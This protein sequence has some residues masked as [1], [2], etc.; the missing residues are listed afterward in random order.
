[1]LPLLLFA[2]LAHASALATDPLSPA[3]G[4]GEWPA[5][6][7]DRDLRWL[8]PHFSRA[9][10]EFQVPRPLL[11]ALA[12]EA[13][14]WDPEVVSQWGGYGLYD[15]REE[16]GGDGPR[17]EDAAML[18][19]VSPDD[20][21]D[22][23]GLQIRAAAAMLA[24]SAA[25]RGDG[26]LPPVDDL[27][28][29]L[30][31]VASFSGRHA[32]NLQDMYAHYVYDVVEHGAARGGLRLPPTPV[33]RID[34]LDL[35]PPPTS[36]DYSG[37]Y[38]FINAS[39]SNYSNYSRGAADISY[40]VVHTVQGSYSG[41]ISWFQNSSAEVSAHYVVRSSDGQVT[42]MVKEEDVAW[43]AG[44]WDYNLASV[45]IEHEGYVES[46]D[47]WYTDAMYSGSAALVSDIIARNGI[48]ASRDYIIGH[49]EVPGATHTD[50]G[51]GWDW[52]TYMSL[53]SG[54]EVT[55]DVI[56]VVADSDIYS[57]DRLVGATVRI[58][59]TGETTTVE[60]DGYYRFYDLPLGSYTMVASYPG[61]DEGSCAKE[62]ASGTNW[63]SIALLPGGG[64]TETGDGGATDGGAT[65]GGTAG[66]GGGG[67]D[68]GP[69]TDG[70][71]GSDGGAPGGDP[72]GPGPVSPPGGVV[73]L[74]DTR[75]G[76]ATAP[77]RAA[78]WLGLA[79]LLGLLLGR[80]RRA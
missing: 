2:G 45:G 48:P 70:G 16:D 62:L 44:N 40:V 24:R 10:A 43:H 32:P 21:V 28:A 31:A 50:P 71:A 6:E 8:G 1:M 58:A 34:W 73:A 17:L 55:G 68:T 59:E 5:S 75:A 37:C 3:S 15:L 66:D 46:P 77:A 67:T 14:R 63:C 20:L 42:Q 29:W 12:W 52:D 39:S 64:G 76:C 54:G 74:D 61:Y 7:A 41:C 53:I 9:A 79:P 65:D 22:D 49:I 80:R 4:L 56:G 13:S 78:A 47:E 38:Q 36:C 19:G 72:G 11:M 35:P 27:G 26:R 33:E 18:L 30:T 57:G 51:T 25:V 60:G 23:P 69:A